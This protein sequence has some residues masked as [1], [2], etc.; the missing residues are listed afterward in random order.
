M[1]LQIILVAIVLAAC[2]G[3]GDPPV[4]AKPADPASDEQAEPELTS[5]EVDRKLDEIEREI[6]DD[7][8]DPRVLAER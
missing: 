3:N 1:R 4:Q 8:S 5:R 7:K 2:S 6:N